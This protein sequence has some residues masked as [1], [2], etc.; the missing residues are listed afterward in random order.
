MTS[1]T[2]PPP[3]PEAREAAAIELL[4]RSAI[5]SSAPRERIRC[6]LAATQ[7]GSNLPA[8]LRCR[9]HLAL[10][11]L[12]HEHADEPVLAVTHLRSAIGLCDR[13]STPAPLRLAVL[14]RSMS[15]GQ[16]LVRSGQLKDARSL[17]ETLQ[18]ALLKGSGAEGDHDAPAPPD[19]TG[20]WL[21][22]HVGVLRVVLLVRDGLL[23]PAERM[24]PDVIAHVDTLPASFRHACM[25]D[26]TVTASQPALATAIYGPTRSALRRVLEFQKASILAQ[27]GELR[28]ATKAVDELLSQTSQ[29]ADA[30]KLDARERGGAPNLDGAADAAINDE[31]R[32]LRASLH[33]TKLEFDQAIALAKELKPI[34]CPFPTPVAASPAQKKRQRDAAQATAPAPSRAHGRA[35]WLLLLAHAALALEE[36]GVANQLVQRAA[37]SLAGTPH[38]AQTVLSLWVKMLECMLDPEQ[39]ETRAETLRSLTVSEEVRSHRLLRGTVFLAQGEA[40]LAAGAAEEAERRLT[41]CVKFCV[42]ESRCDVL[43]AAS[44]TALAAAVGANGGGAA[45]GEASSSATVTSPG[46]GGD[47]GEADKDPKRRRSEDALS[48]A[49]CMAAKMEDLHAQRRTL[50]GWSQHYVNIGDE[51]QATAFGE[52]Y[53]EFE[54]KLSRR[55]RKA[56][57]AHEDFTALFDDRYP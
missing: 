56:R 20:H 48:S 24:L 6:A 17:L 47:G 37:D 29:A 55:L 26:K 4:R 45:D 1:I 42:G 57:G 28:D 2:S 35:S 19:P 34:L 16:G 31:A 21:L 30:A 14:C 41:R 13:P 9:A 22:A 51:T 53:A 8:P 33:V 39:G 12:L 40:S 32:L 10:G 27:Q 46:G 44:L 54:G 36:Y 3:R 11:E 5:A 23:K 25:K 43:A 50:K 38:P 7:A 49:L 52:L 18:G 15:V